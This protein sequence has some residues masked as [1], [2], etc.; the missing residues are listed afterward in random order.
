MEKEMQGK[1]KTKKISERVGKTKHPGECKRKKNEGTNER[2]REKNAFDFTV[3]Q[4]SDHSTP[5]CAWQERAKIKKIDSESMQHTLLFEEYLRTNFLFGPTERFVRYTFR[6]VSL[7]HA[8]AIRGAEVSQSNQDTLCL[9]YRFT[10]SQS[11]STA[12]Y[13]HLLINLYLEHSFFDVRT[14]WIAFI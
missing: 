4:V 13:N 10:S 6:F 11:L 7:S 2:S 5:P 12:I 8:I 1:T 9:C 3:S 14:C